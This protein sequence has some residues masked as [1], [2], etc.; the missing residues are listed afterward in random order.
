MEFHKNI[1]YQLVTNLLFRT[2]VHP[3]ATIL[4]PWI[5]LYRTGDLLVK[6]GFAWDGASG[7]VIDRKTNYSASCA[8]DALYRLM[9][10]G[11][12][13]HH[14]WAQADLEYLRLLKERGEAW[15]I[16]IWADKVGLAFAKGSHAHPSKL[17]KIHLA[18]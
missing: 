6:S 12:L 11:L 1:K 10:K 9:Q 14:W 15:P 8:H 7:P 18:P 4:T 16:T 2:S 5:H 3:G 13:P 17:K